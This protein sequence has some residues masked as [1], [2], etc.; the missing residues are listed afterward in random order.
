MS[1]RSGPGGPAL[2]PAGVALGLAALGLAA[3]GACGGAREPEAM[4]I[5]GTS[6]DLHRATITRPDGELRLDAV[7]ALGLS[8]LPLAC[9]DRPQ[10]A[11]RGSGY[12]FESSY[13]MR[14]DFEAARAFY[15]C[16][17]WHSAVNSTWSLV[18][19]MRRFPELPVAPLI[20]EKLQQHLAPS[21]LAGEAEFFNANP[22]FERPYG[23]AWYLALHAELGRL[24]HPR[25]GAWVESTAPLAE[26]FASGLL[27]YLDRLDYPMRTGTH[28]NTA[29]SLML[30]LDFA[31]ATGRRAV[32]TA[33]VQSAHRL[34]AADVDCPLGY[35]P[36]A[37]DFLSPC[38]SEAA[39]MADVLGPEELRGW[40]DA[41]LPGPDAA[42]FQALRT[43]IRLAGGGEALDIGQQGAKSHLIGLAFT[44]AE[45]LVRIA[46]ALGPG[47][48]RSEAYR[49]I[50]A[51][52]A[53]WGLSAMFD[54][55]YLGS[56][57]IG[58]F[59]LRYL[60]ALPPVPDGE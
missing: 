51:E 52:L 17:D 35:E 4:E 31:R 9:I 57:W 10:G 42:A 58:T 29:F 18:A 12:L 50:A 13:R 7:T 53:T 39:L 6:D 8:A 38:L 30:A 47:D 15:G 40:L 34:Y 43:P 25:A 45:A 3:L 14:P 21:A 41:F 16:Y 11:P 44:R 32:E 36:S 5:S 55:D 56:H 60:L 20:T 1:G 2:R 26:R 24:R 19:L 22:S 33:I 48:P 27:S 49:G 59:A 46:G 37:S 23:W 54:A 28:A